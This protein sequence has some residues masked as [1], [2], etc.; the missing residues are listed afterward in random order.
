MTNRIIDSREKLFNIAQR[1]AEL[2]SSIIEHIDDVKSNSI[3][4]E[5]IEGAY[6]ELFDEE[7]AFLR[8]E[9]ITM[10]CPECGFECAR[11][12]SYCMACGNKLHEQLF[13]EDM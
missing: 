9:E 8:E 2:L 3:F 5:E 6:M 12:S 13:K 7:A 10:P 4:I 11:I 1:K